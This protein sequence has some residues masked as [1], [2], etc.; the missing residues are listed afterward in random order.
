LFSTKLKSETQT[1]TTDSGGNIR[2]SNVPYSKMIVGIRIT[3]PGNTAAY[4]MTYV[5]N[6]NNYWGAQFRDASG[7][8]LKNTSVSLDLLYYDP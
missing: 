2:I 8:L 4:L 5:L 7:D 1:G 6:G 3:S